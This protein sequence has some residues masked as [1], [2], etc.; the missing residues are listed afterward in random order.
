LDQREIGSS[1]FAIF[2]ILSILGS[3]LGRRNCTI[4]SRC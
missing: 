4:C 2:K 1:M 3:F